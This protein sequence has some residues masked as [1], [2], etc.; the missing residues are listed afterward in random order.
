[1]TSYFHNGAKNLFFE[2]LSTLARY[3]ASEFHLHITTGIYFILYPITYQRIFGQE[4][5]LFKV[6]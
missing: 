2:I 3:N 4:R 1:M 5:Q 6:I